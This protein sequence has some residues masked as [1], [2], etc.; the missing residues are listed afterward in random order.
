MTPRAAS[1]TLYCWQSLWIGCDSTQ[2]TMNSPG[3]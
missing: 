2:A 1:I 3:S